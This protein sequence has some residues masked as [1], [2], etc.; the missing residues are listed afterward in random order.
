MINSKKSYS[1]NIQMEIKS[2]TSERIVAAVKVLMLE[3]ALDEITL[4]QIA[5]K[6]HVS[7]QTLF[8]HFGSREQ[9]LREAFEI[10]G[11]EILKNHV[12]PEE[13]SVQSIVANLINYYEE[14]GYRILRLRSQ[15]KQLVAYGG[16]Q[17][18]W[19]MSHHLWVDNS[20]SIYLQALTTVNKNELADT[21]FGATDV[22]IWY[23]Y[24]HDLQKSREELNYIWVRLLRSLLLSYR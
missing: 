9:L 17:T 20:F 14:N 15:S 3:N 19:L 13:V 11:L 6:A 8:R 10:I 22:S 23:V 4:V 21:L 18:E 12:I 2:R 7:I 24:Y 5:E 1:A 16:F